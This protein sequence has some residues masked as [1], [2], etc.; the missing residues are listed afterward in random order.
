MDF[1]TCRISWLA[2]QKHILE[3]CKSLQENN[4]AKVT[5]EDIF[6]EDIL[7]LKY[8][9]AIIESTMERFEQMEAWTIHGAALWSGYMHTEQN[10]K[11][12]YL[13]STSWKLCIF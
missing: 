7:H 1:G 5:K 3:K 8:V 2:T 6:Q 9:E 10:S 11:H 12:L 13:E 4:S